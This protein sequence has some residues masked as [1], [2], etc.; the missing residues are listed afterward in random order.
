MKFKSTKQFVSYLFEATALLDPSGNQVLDDRGNAIY[1]DANRNRVDHLFGRGPFDP[2]PKGQAEYLYHTSK[3]YYDNEN[4]RKSQEAQQ[5]AEKAARTLEKLTAEYKAAMKRLKDP[6]YQSPHHQEMLKDIVN[7]LKESFP[8]IKAIVEQIK[9]V[10]EQLKRFPPIEKMKEFLNL[11]VHPTKRAEVQSKYFELT[12]KLEELE[13]NLNNEY[14]N[15]EKSI[16]PESAQLEL[17]GLKESI[18]RKELLNYLSEVESIYTP[19]KRK[20]FV[21]VGPPSVGKSTWISST[22]GAEQPYV[23]NRD[24]IVDNVA[25]EY[26]WTYDD[27][28]VTP[29]SDSE[30][31][32]VDE[33]YG[34]VNAA[35]SWMTWAKTVFSKVMEANNKVQQMFQQKVSGIPSSDQ[36]VVVDMTNMNAG[37]RSGALKMIGDADFEKIAVVFEFEGAEDFIKKVAEKRAEAAKRMGKSKTI[38]SAAFDRMFKAFSRPTSEEGFDQIVSVDNREMLKKLANNEPLQEGFFFRK[39]R[40]YREF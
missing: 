14:A 22:F 33:K 24:D 35:P 11:N 3:K 15:L 26:G 13:K 30:I 29:P 10:K 21:L 16:E 1:H 2:N 36:D 8:Q 25:S 34:T 40:R 19:K 27:M 18:I 38:P 17:P 7:Q 23:I 37:A 28:F 9:T 32:A 6:K 20:L 31:D 4:K 39:N 5:A 12:E